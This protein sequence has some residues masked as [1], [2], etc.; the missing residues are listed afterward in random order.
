M[1]ELQL[2][3]SDSAKCSMWWVVRKE[4]KKGKPDYY[5]PWHDKNM[6]QK[7]LDNEL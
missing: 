1:F 5:G 7:F 2:M 4:E 3:Y 6:A